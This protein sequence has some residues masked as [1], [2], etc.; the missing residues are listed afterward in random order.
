MTCTV[1]SVDDGLLRTNTGCM[2]PLFSSIV[3]VD[4]LKKITKAR[5]YTKN[6]RSTNSKSRL[7]HFHRI[8]II[9]SMYYRNEVMGGQ[10]SGYYS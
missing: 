1:I 4:S 5:A 6:F 7:H 2:C 9:L 8:I 10:S 3:Y